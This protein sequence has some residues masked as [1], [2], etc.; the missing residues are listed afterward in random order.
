ME[1]SRTTEVKLK[2][3]RVKPRLSFQT[4]EQPTQRAPRVL[5]SKDWQHPS[6]PTRRWS[7]LPR[8]RPSPSRKR[9]MKV[10]P[11]LR[12]LART[13]TPESDDFLKQKPKKKR[14]RKKKRTTWVTREAY[15]EAGKEMKA[16]QTKFEGFERQM[17]SGR[18]VGGAPSSSSESSCGD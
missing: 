17:V 1:L 13:R 14:K 9:P 16:L 18:R 11:A 2:G 3:N 12:V 5:H 4:K 15:D 6:S 8:K 7:S 10:P